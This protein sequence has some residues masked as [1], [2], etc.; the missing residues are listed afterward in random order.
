MN[1]QKLHKILKELYQLQLELNGQK[2][3]K[4]KTALDPLIFYS[5]ELLQAK[6]SIQLS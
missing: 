3:Y 4:I 5:Q 6:K 1:I 2:L